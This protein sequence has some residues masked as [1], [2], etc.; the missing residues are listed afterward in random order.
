MFE[1]KANSDSNVN[2]NTKVL[3]F[4]IG[5]RIFRRPWPT[6]I[7]NAR[8]LVSLWNFHFKASKI[9]RAD[10]CVKSIPAKSCVMQIKTLWLDGNVVGT[11]KPNFSRVTSSLWIWNSFS[12]GNLQRGEPTR[13]IIYCCDDWVVAGEDWGDEFSFLF[14]FLWRF[15]GGLRTRD[16]RDVDVEKLPSFIISSC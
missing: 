13:C 10:F 11:V 14:D 7:I 2:L 1:V 5:K 9:Q 15:C 16:L 8:T 12:G 4:K 3:I 6:T